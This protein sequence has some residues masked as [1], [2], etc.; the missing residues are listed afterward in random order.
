ME[1]KKEKKEKDGKD[2]AMRAQ[3]RYVPRN[4]L[5]AGG[6][7]GGI[8]ICLT[9]PLEYAKCQLQLAQLAA[10]A[11]APAHRPGGL[12]RVFK[13]TI[14]TRG[15]TGLYSG[16]TPWLLFSFPRAAFRFSVYERV[17]ALH[18]AYFA[19]QVRAFSD[20]MHTL[21]ATCV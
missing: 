19:A 11:D 7:T 20:T 18:D 8:E 3:G 14:R 21:R 9:Y 1:G 15:L 4:P 17:L 10:G 13:E 16:L 12:L 5:L 6:I 2:N